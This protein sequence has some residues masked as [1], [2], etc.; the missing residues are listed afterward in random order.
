MTEFR[1]VNPEQTVLQ[2]ENG[3]TSLENAEPM[4]D[5]KKSKANKAFNWPIGLLFGTIFALTLDSIALGISLGVVFAL[6]FKN[7]E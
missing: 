4:S 6:V 2:S 3:N 5:T 1:P 7:K